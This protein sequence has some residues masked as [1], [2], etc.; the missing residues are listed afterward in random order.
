[1]KL[2][3]LL[4]T[5]IAIDYII[6][7]NISY[8]MA[9]KIAKIAKTIEDNQTFYAEKVQNLIKEYGELDEKGNPIVE[10]DDIK[11][12]PEHQTE[13]LAKLHELQDVEVE[14]ELI[15]KKEFEQE[16][17]KYGIA[18]SPRKVFLLNTLMQ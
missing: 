8:S 3:D 1:M 16:C 10:N 15:D 12:K 9:Y 2:I 14:C 6:D 13:F 18:I 4:N 5:K 7:Q 17:S 11:I